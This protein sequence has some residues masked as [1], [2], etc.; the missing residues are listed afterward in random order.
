M[1]DR[2]DSGPGVRRRGWR[3]RVT[4]L[5]MTVAMMS[6]AAVLA[7]PGSAQAGVF[8][9]DIACPTDP[10]I[11]WTTT[12]AAR[13]TVVYQGHLFT[14]TSANRTFIAS[15]GRTVDNGLSSPI[16]ATFTSQQSRTYTVITKVGTSAELTSK[17]QATVSVDIQYSRTTAIGVNAQVT[18]PAYSRVLGL[19]GVEV[20][21]VAYTAQRVWMNLARSKCWDRGTQSD[22]TSAP[23]LVEGWRFTAG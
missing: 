11:V 10:S 22:T 8:G 4:G 18:V 21:D 19:Y 14:V 7:V 6:G 17:L 20:Y 13:N 12:V 16:T 15:D 2:A 9:P 23:T 1:P 3:A 5:V